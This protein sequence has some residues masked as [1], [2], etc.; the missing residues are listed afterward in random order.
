M[1]PA[2]GGIAIDL[3][4]VDRKDRR[5]GGNSRAWCLLTCSLRFCARLQIRHEAG[6]C[7]VLPDFG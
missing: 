1:C 2:S 7:R 3:A 5:Y 6:G 4:R